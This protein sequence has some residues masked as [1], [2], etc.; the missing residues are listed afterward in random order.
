MGNKAKLAANVEVKETPSR[1]G[2]QEYVAKS[3]DSDEQHHVTIGKGKIFHIC[4]HGLAALWAQGIFP[5]LVEYDDHNE[6]RLEAYWHNQAAVE[7]I[8][9]DGEVLNVTIL[10]RKEKED[11]RTDK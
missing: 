3:E 9:E 11:D 1:S 5:A 7:A 6:V 10:K 2:M 8:M 4:K